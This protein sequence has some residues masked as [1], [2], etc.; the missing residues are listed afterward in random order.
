MYTI[1]YRFLTDNYIARGI[2][3]LRIIIII[4]NTCVLERVKTDLR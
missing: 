1:T 2:A 3:R 4:N